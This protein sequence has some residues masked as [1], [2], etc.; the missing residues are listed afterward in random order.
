MDF[1][2]R[3]IIIASLI[4]LLPVSVIATSS[5]QQSSSI[6]KWVD[7]AGKV[8]FSDHATSSAAEEHSLRPIDYIEVSSDIKSKVARER[9]RLKSQ[10]RA[11]GLSPGASRTTP[12]IEYADY[13]FSNMSAAQKLGYV[14]LSGRISGGQRC[15]K[16]RIRA[17]AES[18]IGKQVTGVQVVD[19]AGFGSSLFEIRKKTNRQSGARQPQW[20]IADVGAVCLRM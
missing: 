13:R 17:K 14:M 3:L 4:T 10:Q 6:Y 9:A 7:R 11:D 2:F 8:H 16:L 20:Q 15:Q 18:D 5:T 1:R 12:S 19:Y